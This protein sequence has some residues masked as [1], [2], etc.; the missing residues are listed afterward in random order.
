METPRRSKRKNE[1]HISMAVIPISSSK[2]KHKIS[3]KMFKY[4]KKYYHKLLYYS[5]MKYFLKA[6]MQSIFHIA[7]RVK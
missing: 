7:S 2:Y 6:L 4:H 1:L 3:E 5:I